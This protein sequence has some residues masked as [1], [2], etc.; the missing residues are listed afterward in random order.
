LALVGDLEALAVATAA[1]VPFVSSFFGRA[2]FL[3]VASLFRF[4]PETFLPLSFS[5]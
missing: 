2:N 5:S 4:C 3:V 1:A